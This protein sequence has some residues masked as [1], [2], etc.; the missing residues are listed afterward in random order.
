MAPP[1][2]TKADSDMTEIVDGGVSGSLVALEGTNFAA[3]GHVF[4][5]DVPSNIVSCPSPYT[6][7]S[8]K[9]DGCGG[10]TTTAGCFV[11]FN[12]HEAKSRHV[13]PIG[14]LKG[15]RF[16][17]IFR[18]KVWWTT[19]W[20]GSNGS[21]LENETQIVILDKSSDGGALNDSGRPYVLL[22]PLIEG[23][24]R[25][26]LQ[27]GQDDDIDI[28]VESGSTKVA[29]DSFRSALYIHAGDDPYNLVKEAIKVAR[30]HL[31]TF[32]LLKEK[33]PPGIVDKFGWC[34]W[35]AFYLS[36]HPQGVWEGVNGL[37]KGG[38]PPGLVLIDD[39]WQSISHDDDPVAEEGVNRTSAGEY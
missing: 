33:T 36:V 34:T 9:S 21:D 1:S 17:S 25:A 26:S 38:C 22:L 13:V 30:I 29:G 14:K 18:F 35:D 20:V 8:A 4:L 27:A 24:F 39:G 12:A 23:P 7:V 2:L 10:T 19:H 3:N 16:M 15:I 32:K 11:G 37:V 6:T 28:C 5:S 31:G